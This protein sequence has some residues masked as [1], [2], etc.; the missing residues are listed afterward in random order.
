MTCRRRRG[1]GV[2]ERGRDGL[3]AAARIYDD[4]EPPPGSLERPEVIFAAG[5]VRG[6]IGTARQAI[7]FFGRGR[8]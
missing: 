6:G 2:Y 8:G 3:L 5:L 7:V 1:S 4:V